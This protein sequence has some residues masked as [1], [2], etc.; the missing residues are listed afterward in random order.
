LHVL[1]AV[2]GGTARHLVDVVRHTPDVDHEVVVP[3]RRVGWMTD[4]TATAAMSD[5][6][7]RVHHVEMRRTPV[8][9][10]NAAAL[11]SL[12]RLVATTR[13]DIV[14]GHSSVGGALARLAAW[15]LTVP[16]VY[17]PNGVATAA[18]A[19]AVERLL[20]RRTQRL[21]AASASEGEL[22]IRLGLVSRERLAVVPNGIDPDLPPPLVPDIRT[23]L[24]LGP[25]IRLVGCVARLVP[26]KA[27]LDYVRVCSQVAR[28]NRDVHFLLVGSGPLAASLENE[29]SRLGLE[30]RFHRIA[31][32][33][34][35][36]GALADLDVVVST[37]RFEGGPYVPM[38][39]MR[40]GT[41]V[42][43]TDV[44]GNRDVVEHGVSG[45]LVLPDP[46]V[47][48]GH[49]AEDVLALL[50]DESLRS[51]FATAGKRR[52]SELFN[53]GRMGQSLSSLYKEVRLEPCLTP[54]A[55]LA[56]LLAGLDPKAPVASPWL[57]KLRNQPSNDSL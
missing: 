16:C 36:A 43:L 54:T 7:A 25:D 1:E 49:L 9:G 45:L 47:L 46:D 38:E 39:A 6:G 57:G 51:R 56:R 50:G 11:R 19:V 13:P 28:R 48:V 41:P 40:V 2:G 42:V 32:L 31:E 23:R 12:R 22:A 37:A 53:V 21:V 8:H 18:P 35:A 30:G 52:I 4:E 24:G 5:A 14:H 20:G 15:D 27:P 3:S 10:R 29:V 17:T 34:G 26:Q 44:V 55:R 33:P